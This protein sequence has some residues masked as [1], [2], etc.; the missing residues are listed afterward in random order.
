MLP[1]IALNLNIRQALPYVGI[2]GTVMAVVITFLVVVLAYALRKVAKR[3]VE[4]IVQGVRRKPR[5]FDDDD[6]EPTTLYVEKFGKP[7]ITDIGA[8]Q[9]TFKSAERTVD[10]QELRG[11]IP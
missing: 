5:Q 7:K 9:R 10:L 1:E 4:K 3:G 11:L 6:D 8:R 2:L